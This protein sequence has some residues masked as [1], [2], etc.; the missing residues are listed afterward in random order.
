MS[1]LEEVFPGHLAQFGIAS[2]DESLDEL[3]LSTIASN[4]SIRVIQ[5]KSALPKKL[6]RSINNNLLALRPD[7]TVRVYGHYTSVCNFS[8]LAELSNLKRFSASRL[9]DA[10]NV[11]AIEY[12]KGLE[13]LSIEIDSLTSFDFLKPNASSLQTLRL[14]K[15]RSKRPDLA[16]LSGLQSL[17]AVNIH[18]QC[19]SVDVIGKLGALKSVSLSGAPV[20]SFNFLAD[21]QNLR[22]LALSG[23]P[24]EAVLELP[25]L[26]LE[27][28]SISEIRG[29]DDL[30]FLEGRQRLAELTLMDLRNVKE[31]PSL[32]SLPRLKYLFIENL[33]ALRSMNGLREGGQLEEFI[34]RASSTQLTVE[35]FSI[36]A[37]LPRLRR[38][39]VGTGSQR[40]NDSIASLL[41]DRGIHTA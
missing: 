32:K 20:K 38:A 8:F 10:I 9:L 21:L 4:P 11:E 28:L 7:I 5:S 6:W 35:D 29:L 26:D 13:E 31:L 15:T 24:Q 36:L 34:H 12:V 23:V 2:I 22:E 1:I 18:G 40:K 33:K 3:T 37:S 39:T 30:S 25:K 19:K 16:V 41:I 17:K 14:G 27:K